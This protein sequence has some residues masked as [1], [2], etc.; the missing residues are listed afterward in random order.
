MVEDL[1]NIPDW[2]QLAFK[3]DILEL[4]T[5]VKPFLLNHL[6]E[7]HGLQKLIYFDPDIY[8]FA[9]LDRILSLLDEN[10]AVVTPHITQPIEDECIPGEAE[11]LQVGTFNLGFL[12]IAA[13]ATTDAFLRWWQKRLYDFCL[14]NAPLGYF[15]DQKWVNLA[16]D[17]FGGFYSLRDSHYNIAYWNLHYRA[18]RLQFQGHQ[19]LLDDSPICFFHFSGFRPDQPE[20]VSKYQN[21]IEF[22]QYP[23][24]R[25][26][27]EFYA[28][29]LLQCGFNEA[30]KWTYVYGFF[31]NGVAIPAMARVAYQHLDWAQRC[32]FGD[33]FQTA[34][35]R[36]FFTWVSRDRQCRREW[37]VQVVGNALRQS[38]WKRLQMLGRAASLDPSV[39]LTH[40]PIV[41]RI[42]WFLNSRLPK[43]R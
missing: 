10:A 12:A 18:T 38:L 13:G 15:T 42:Y 41:S 28:D 11:F 21:R 36:T 25:P 8:L 1:P 23:N 4:N 33:P 32:N 37:A 43:K 5:A 2:N 31:D 6:L 17:L 39:I 27:F 3:Y 34:G 26:I 24:L 19:A 7:T 14:A 30:K 20:T 35:D 40:F 29:E 22:K 16:P 9:P